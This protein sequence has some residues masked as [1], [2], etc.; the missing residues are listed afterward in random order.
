MEL[1]QIVSELTRR[2]GNTGL[3]QRTINDYVSAFLPEPGTEP[4]EA[5]W[6]KHVGIIK[7]LGG[8]YSHDVA[9]KVNEF[10]RTYNPNHEP[11]K[12]VKP[13]DDNPNKALLERLSA[14]EA[15]V[16][17]RDENEK[18]D[19]LRNGVIEKAPE[20]K[21]T[22][23]ALWKDVAGLVEIPDGSTHDSLLDSVKKLYESKLKLYSGDGAMP[24]GGPKKPGNSVD[25]KEANDR[26]EKFMA[27]M[28]ANGRLPQAN[29]Q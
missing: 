20:L 1:E 22:N 27:K 9:D 6:T 26:R 21:V 29:P 8:N 10:K 15:K 16:T 24:Y 17:G 11:N 2:A 18:M 5:Y 3:S 7:S 23:V 13:Q 25:Q 12:D 28:R 19:A 4:D 14:L